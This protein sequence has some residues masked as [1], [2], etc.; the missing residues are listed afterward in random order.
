VE[1]EGAVH[2]RT[3]AAGSSY[4]DPELERMRAERKRAFQEQMADLDRTLAAIETRRIESGIARAPEDVE[5]P[6]SR[7]SRQI[8]DEVDRTVAEIEA[9]R[10]EPDQPFDLEAMRA[11]RKRAFR[12]QMAEVDR[13]VAAIEARRKEPDEPFDLEAMRAERRLH[14]LA[15]ERWID[16]GIR[17]IEERRAA[18]NWRPATDEEMQADL[19]R[20]QVELFAWIDEREERIARRRRGEHPVDDWPWAEELR[21]IRDE[22]ARGPQVG[23]AKRLDDCVGPGCCWVTGV[24]AAPLLDP[25]V[26]GCDADGAASGRL[27]PSELGW[28]VDTTSV[29]VVELAGGTWRMFMQSPTLSTV[30]ATRRFPF[31]GPEGVG[32]YAAYA[33]LHDGS[34]H[35]EN[36][37]NEADEWWE[38]NHGPDA[39]DLRFSDQFIAYL[40]STDPRSFPVY[41]P[42]V[43]GSPDCA[44]GDCRFVGLGAHFDGVFGAFKAGWTPTRVRCRGDYVVYRDVTVLVLPST[45]L[46]VMFA[47]ACWDPLRADRHEVD[48]DLCTEKPGVIPYTNLVYFLSASGTFRDDLRGPYQAMSVMPDQAQGQWLGVPAA[49]TDP[50]GRF[51]F[52]Y[53]PGARSVDGGL[54]PGMYA[55]RME[56]FERS[57]SVGSPAVWGAPDDRPELVRQSGFIKPPDLGLDANRSYHPGTARSPF[58]DDQDGLGPSGEISGER[59]AYLDV[60][61]YLGQVALS[62]DTPGTEVP[63]EPI[64]EEFIFCP[65]GKLTMFFANRSSG[66]ADDLP[67]L[68]TRAPAASHFVFKLVAGP[69]AQVRTLPGLL[70]DWLQLQTPG[71]MPPSVEPLSHPTLRAALLEFTADCNV[72]DASVLDREVNDPEAV[73]VDGE[74]LVH[75]HATH[76]PDLGDGGAVLLAR[77]AENDPC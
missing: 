21:Q 52:V 40:D 44:E 11:E 22:L 48:R 27:D 59:P 54:N 71:P 68:I 56:D 8:S 37:N 42:M 1:G 5:V 15:R 33:C 32:K 30:D 51:L 13:T 38:M 61:V 66:D 35:Q 12:E 72:V 53:L 45:G 4:V 36:M 24:V 3:P 70:D 29:S 28:W 23:E 10:R 31:E 39:R 26:W 19:E 14:R 63:P 67:D 58:E 47:V 69:G 34:P 76:V 2:G 73:L 64:D 62:G 43:D 17:A 60:F 41:T 74:L 75:Y 7:W 50:A 25:L 57:I 16:N 46:H 77:S 6:L 49:F 18:Y 65:S 20:D 55:A 9:R